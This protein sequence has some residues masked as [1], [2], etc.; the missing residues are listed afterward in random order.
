MLTFKSVFAEELK[1]ILREQIASRM[2]DLAYGASIASFEDYREAVGVIRGLTTAI[3]AVDE[4][5]EKA[6]DRERG[7]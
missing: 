5:E 2:N 7:H 4:A 3:D 1:K 6:N